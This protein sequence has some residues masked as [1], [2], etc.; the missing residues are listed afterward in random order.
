MRESLAVARQVGRP[1][2]LCEVLELWEEVCL[3]QQRLDQADTT[4]DEIKEVAAGGRLPANEAAAWYGLARVALAQG[5]HEEARTWA[6]EPAHL[7]VHW[8][9]QG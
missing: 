4:F 8:Q 3:K 5:Q 1:V 2:L 7:H 9:P 6:G